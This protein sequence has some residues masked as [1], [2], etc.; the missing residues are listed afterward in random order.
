MSPKSGELYFSREAIRR[1]DQL[2]I[3]RYDIPGIVLMENAAS[4][5]ARTLLRDHHD[6]TGF[7]IFCGPG[8]NGGDGLAIARH[9][10]N[11]RTNVT[12]VRTHPVDRYTGDART[13]LDICTRMELPTHN[14]DALE[15]L[16]PPSSSL[17]VVDALL[18]TGSQSVP[19]GTLCECTLHIN[20]LRA[21][22]NASV[23][24]ID[25][26]S[27][28]DCDTG[29]PFDAQKCVRASRTLTMAGLK[30]GFANAG[31]AEFAGEIEVI[32]IGVPVQL[33]DELGE[34]SPHG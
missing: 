24:A 8:N 25:L 11:A 33:L 32:D 31:A 14:V 17:C 18:G 15:T 9:L 16:P 21:H 20:T 23:I 4:G 12:I 19:R 30:R 3:E 29:E 10:H 5:C 26:P 13:N 2:A 6:T 22:S 1:V 28:L 27:G 34:E 7:L